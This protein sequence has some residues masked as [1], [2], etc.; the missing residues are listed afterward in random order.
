MITIRALRS[1]ELRQ[2]KHL[3]RSHFEQ[4]AESQTRG[5]QKTQAQEASPYPHHLQDL[6]AETLQ[7][8]AEPNP[9]QHILNEL[10]L[11]N[12]PLHG[13]S[14]LLPPQ[15]QFMPAM[16]VA[17][18]PEHVL[19]LIC[20]SQD[21]AKKSRWRIDEMI[22]DADVSAY[23]VGSQLL[24]Y[25]IN[26]YGGSGVQTF[27]AK[28]SP[29]QDQALGLFKSCGFRHCSRVHLYRH[30]NP[31]S[32]FDKRDSHLNKHVGIQGLRPVNSNDYDKLLQLDR[33]CLPVETRLSLEKDRLDFQQTLSQNIN[34]R[35][36]G[37][38]HVEWVVEDV[39]RDLLMG[40]LRI[41]SVDFKHYRV[42][43]LAHHAWPA[44]VES[45]VDRALRQIV[46][47][48]RSAEVEIEVYD[49]HKEQLAHL[50]AIGFERQSTAEILVKDYWIQLNEPRKGHRSP[51]L[52][53]E[54]GR[55]SPAVNYR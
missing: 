54:G 15:W 49:C 40:W 55:T 25:V 33:E 21:G 41:E 42:T 12:L 28:V 8:A 13:L 31:A 35:L 3:L 16:F 43:F 45:L 6:T 23:D 5:A 26:R 2:V 7:D 4:P 27:I 50:E 39:A 51:L 29:D 52:I 36:Q 11:L 1:K 32:R 37:H 9:Y 19:G 17:A 10:N 48:T 30:P 34:R 38:L 47:T 14:Q 53:F 24:N 46:N 18:S 20:L 44:L 22:I